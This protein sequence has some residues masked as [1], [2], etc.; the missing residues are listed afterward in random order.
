MFTFDQPDLEK[1][2]CARCGKSVS[3][4]AYQYV[5]AGPDTGKYYHPDCYRLIWIE[6]AE[7]FVKFLMGRE[8]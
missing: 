1:G 7:D 8:K 3:V 2:P 4:R 6:A 5:A